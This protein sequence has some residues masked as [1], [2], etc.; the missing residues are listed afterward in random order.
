MSAKDTVRNN[1]TKILEILC[2]DRSLILNK[3][4]EKNLITGREYQNLKIIYGKDEEGH[5]TEL[6][7]KIMTKGENTCQY[8][9]TLLQTDEDIKSTFPELKNIQLNHNQLLPKPVQASSWDI[10]DDNSPECKRQKKY[11]LNS[12]PVGLCV[13]INNEN[14]KD[15]NVRNGTNKD[16]QSLSEVFSGLGFRVLMCKDQTKDQ[17]DRALKYFA[18]LSGDLSQLQ[19]F[20][21]KEWSHTEFTELQQPLQHGD[22][23]ICCILSHGKKG[24]VFGIDWQPLCIK[25]IT[26]NFKATDQSPLTGKPKVFLIQACQ[27]DK[28]QHGVIL[29]DV[30]ADDSSLPSI[31][32][33][34]DFL[35]AYATVEDHAA[36]RHKTDGSWFVQSLCQQ[37]QR[38][39]PRGEDITTILHR[40]NNEVGQKEGSS[41]VGAAKQMPEVRFTLRK[42][43]VLS[44]Q[45]NYS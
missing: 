15:G 36:F 12:Q 10:R 21:V 33:E 30:E 9:L 14:F 3:V 4:H 40:V 17:M 41:Q 1:K 29:T 43:L 23:F 45:S 18:S 35:V 8:F 7:D 34:G 37:L 24:V 6:V 5:V 13:I 27:G 32:E 28:T 20:N 39:C 19:E 22:A 2:G 25:Q 38:H 31:P 26:R 42:K 44:P 11:R 16:T